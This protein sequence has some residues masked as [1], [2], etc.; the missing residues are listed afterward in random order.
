MASEQ[1]TLSDFYSVI[2]DF[3]V[4]PAFSTQH[5]SE[6]DTK[7]FLMFFRIHHYF[8]RLETVFL[9]VEYCKNKEF[10]LDAYEWKTHY[11][12]KCPQQPCLK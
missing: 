6:I 11:M 2:L 9:H 3:P 8:K 7:K 10:Y 4:F 1:W 12:E 5:M